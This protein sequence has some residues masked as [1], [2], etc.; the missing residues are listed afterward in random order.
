MATAT[1]SVC[2]LFNEELKCAICLHRLKKPRALVCLH[3][4][5]ERCLGKYVVER[6][7]SGPV[8]CPLCQ[9]ETALSEGGVAAL[10]SDFRALKLIEVLEQEER[11]SKRK[12]I[13]YMCDVC[14]STNAQGNALYIHC[15]ECAQVMCEQ[16]G[17]AHGKM[18]ISQSHAVAPV[19]N[20]EEKYASSSLDTSEGGSTNICPNHEGYKLDTFCITC[21]VPVCE[22]CIT[23]DHQVGE[24]HEHVLLSEFVP[25]M[26]EQLNTRLAEISDRSSDHAMFL[27]VLSSVESTIAI[28]EDIFERKVEVA[29][30][31]HVSR[32]KEDIKTKREKFL[33][34]QKRELKKLREQSERVQKSLKLNESNVKDVLEPSRN[35][36]DLARSFRS[37]RES[38][39]QALSERPDNSGLEVISKAISQLQF[40]MANDKPLIGNLM[41]PYR[42]RRII[43]IPKCSSGPYAAICTR[44]GRLAVVAQFQGAKIEPLQIDCYKHNGGNHYMYNGVQHFEPCTYYAIKQTETKCEFSS[45]FGMEIRIDKCYSTLASLS[46]LRFAC[47]HGIL[48]SNVGTVGT[49]TNLQLPLTVTCV[50]TDL[51]DNIYLA[52]GPN[53]QL[54]VYDKHGTRRESI[55]TGILQPH[56]IALCP[57]DPKEILM[58]PSDKSNIIVIDRRGNV[59]RTIDHPAW[60]EVT[61]GVDND[62]LVHVLWKDSEGYRTLQRYS[63]E[64]HLIDTL[65]EKEQ[66]GC[67]EL[68]LAVSPGGTVAVVTGQSKNAQITVISTTRE[69]SEY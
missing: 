26:S 48:I 13:V 36:I 68:I 62:R 45:A 41:F 17:N 15:S 32:W 35:H 25:T 34:L 10:P 66:H 43:A 55:S 38:M 46:D 53:N 54:Y 21:L 27:S 64:G 61:I 1:P 6:A 63:I 67:N 19:S 50:V 8:I 28:Q 49:F 16:C 22:E 44:D 39:D 11:Q 4:F 33:E 51:G 3:S 23:T 5:C 31:Q 56:D 12:E 37:L 42:D 20:K 2:D 65:F 47:K 40:H 29:I 9:K 59:L 52:D 7:T 14:G 57:R 30:R 69:L 24:N 18:R 60:K 58:T